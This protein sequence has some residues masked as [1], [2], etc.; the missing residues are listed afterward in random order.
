MESNNKKTA[1]N[2]TGIS[3]LTI[4]NIG[5]T[6]DVLVKIAEQAKG[7]AV[8][9]ARIVGQTHAMKTGETSK[10]EYVEFAGMFHADNYH[11]GEA[12]RSA[13]LILPSICSGALEAVLAQAK[14]GKKEGEV[15]SVVFGYE[16]MVKADTKSA[17]GYVFTMGTL[18]QGNDPLSDLLAELPAIP[19]VKLLK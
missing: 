19:K 2:F 9:I 3:K 6:K 18:I 10:G 11:D 8:A 7:K 1:P 4:A 5:L 16:V 15:S 17:V 14:N 13:K 12:Y